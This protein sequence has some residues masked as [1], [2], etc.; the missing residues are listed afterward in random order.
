[1][2][3]NVRSEKEMIESWLSRLAANQKEREDLKM[4]KLDNDK[5]EICSGIEAVQLYNCIRTIARKRQILLDLRI[6]HYA[7]GARKRRW[8]FIFEGVEFYELE[9]IKK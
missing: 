2:M 7:D 1:M 9:D 5:L 3:D 8:N 6:E 4:L